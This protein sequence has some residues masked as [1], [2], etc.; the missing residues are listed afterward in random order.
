M[1]GKK[2]TS[3]ASHVAAIALAIWETSAMAQ[4]STPKPLRE[5]FTATIQESRFATIQQLGLNNPELKLT[6][7]Q[8]VEIDKTIHAY[9]VEQNAV[10]SKLSDSTSGRQSQDALAM[11]SAA[12]DRL[13]VSVGKM[14]TAQQREIMEAARAVRQTQRN[15]RNLGSTR[16]N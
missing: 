6:K 12:R 10:L 4:V 1:V 5:P 9:V 11:R 14:L 16:Q 13:F 8:R 3:I 15:S 7:S 2:W